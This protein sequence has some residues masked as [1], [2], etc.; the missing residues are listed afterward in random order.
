MG[1]FDKFFKNNK[2]KALSEGQK[3]G[4]IDIEN[5]IQ[6][7]EVVNPDGKSEKI[8][9]DPN[10]WGEMNQEEK[11]K[12]L[13]A[14]TVE[15]TQE[16]LVDLICDDKDGKP[17]DIN[18]FRYGINN[19]Y[20]LKNLK[21]LV[22]NILNS[23]NDSEISI[24]D[25][26]KN[27][28]NEFMEMNNG[29]YSEEGKIILENEGKEPLNIDRTFFIDRIGYDTFYQDKG[30]YG[31]VNDLVDLCNNKQNLKTKKQ[32]KYVDVETEVIDADFYKNPQ[33]MKDILKGLYNLCILQNNLNDGKY[34]RTKNR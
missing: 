11:E 15:E 34:L 17:I 21:E 8:Y 29:E 33:K 31:S 5:N 10:I 3:S 1:F 23:Q 28:F 30:D 12:R 27:K 18:L 16:I 20:S 22:L 2:P 6:I 26:I 7:K 9:F 13:L 19:R 24:K 32:R 25:K 4:N 14:Y